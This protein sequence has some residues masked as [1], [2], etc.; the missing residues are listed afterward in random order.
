[1]APSQKPSSRHQPTSA[2]HLSRVSFTWHDARLSQ[3]NGLCSMSV[4]WSLSDGGRGAHV[5]RRPTLTVNG[6]AHENRMS[7][8][9]TV[10]DSD[11]MSPGAKP[12]RAYSR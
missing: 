6:L 4:I 7:R 10:R 11:M 2:P 3:L 12:Y 8:L 1:M 5:T 9:P